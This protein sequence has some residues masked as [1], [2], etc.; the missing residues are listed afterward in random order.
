[1]TDTDKS[2]IEMLEEV[3]KRLDTIEKKINILDRSVKAI[4]NSTKMA[5]LIN[6]AVGTPLDGFARASLPKI[7]SAKE[8]IDEVRKGFKNFKF[9]T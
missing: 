6:K 5:D 1:M 9:E 7:P 4:A 3:L 2:G 8:K